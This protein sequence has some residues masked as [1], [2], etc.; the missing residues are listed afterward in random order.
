MKP[1]ITESL[2]TSSRA[3]NSTG[4]KIRIRT[5]KA[6]DGPRFNKKTG[7]QSSP[8]WGSRSAQETPVKD[9]WE[10]SIFSLTVHFFTLTELFILLIIR[11]DPG[12]SE[13]QRP[14]AAVKPTVLQV[15]VPQCLFP[16]ETTVVCPK[17]HWMTSS[18]DDKYLFMWNMIHIREMSTII[19]MNEIYKSF[20]WLMFRDA[21]YWFI[22]WYSIWQYCSTLNFWF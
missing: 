6:A 7:H 22:C 17:T 9:W 15:E 3:W 19:T 5:L 1:H 14:L 16:A 21:R 18:A 2:L 10:V 11:V 8:T 12:G 4:P 20:W 13:D